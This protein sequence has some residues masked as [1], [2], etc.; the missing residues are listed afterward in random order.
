VIP[1]GGLSRANHNGIFIGAWDIAPEGGR[2][3]QLG[4]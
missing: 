3:C 2:G 1:P 4:V